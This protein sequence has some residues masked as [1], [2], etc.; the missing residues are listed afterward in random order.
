MMQC[1]ETHELL[2]KDFKLFYCMLMKRSLLVDLLPWRGLAGNP[3]LL[4][5][6]HNAYI[7]LILIPNTL[8]LIALW[9]TLNLN[10]QH[11]AT[12]LL[13][14]KYSIASNLP[15]SNSFPLIP[16]LSLDIKT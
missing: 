11:S 8:F 13:N 7:H 10:L 16:N 9:Q 1:V 6:E 12:P 3:L 4:F 15:S 5:I 2:N 14:L